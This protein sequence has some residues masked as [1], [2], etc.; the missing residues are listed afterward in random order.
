M[1]YRK[2]IK[3]NEKYNLRELTI[4]LQYRRNRKKTKKSAK[5]KKL[6]PKNLQKL[7]NYPRKICKSRIFAAKNNDEKPC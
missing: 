2:A 5:N 3:K 1:F 7:K 6:S 4:I